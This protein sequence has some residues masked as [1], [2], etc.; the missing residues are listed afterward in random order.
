MA[1]IMFE[2]MNASSIYLAKQPVLSLYATGRMDGAVVQI[3]HGVTQVI[4]SS[5]GFA[6]PNSCMRSTLA[7]QKLNEYLERLLVEEGVTGLT[8]D[9]VR[10]IKE[11]HCYVAIDFEKEEKQLEAAVK[12][13]Y[14]LPDGI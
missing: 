5:K 6:V 3:G 7:G 11:K 14:T 9:A 12:P 8:A 1:E 13:T 2:G 10:D 4:A